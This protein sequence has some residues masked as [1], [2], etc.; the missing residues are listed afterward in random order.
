MSVS[1]TGEPYEV[2]IGEPG[3]RL[4]F[5]GPAFAE[6][7]GVRLEGQFMTAHDDIVVE[8]SLAEFFARLG[9][10]WRGW[11]GEQVWSSPHTRNMTM[12]ARHDG[13]GHVSIAVALW[14]WRQTPDGPLREPGDWSASLV[15]GVEPPQLAAI[16]R[17]LRQLAS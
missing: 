15:V 9:T 8:P 3:C 1:E 7:V 16:A 17:D 2:V 5:R 13:V 4:I 10:M 14:D 12:A 11:Q 6:H